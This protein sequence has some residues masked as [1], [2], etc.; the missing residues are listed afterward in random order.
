MGAWCRFGRDDAG[1]GV[2]VDPVLQRDTSLAHAPNASFERLPLD[3][4]DM[5]MM[6]TI[7]VA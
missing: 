1:S 2:G 6:G 4:E 3:H 7:E 5:G